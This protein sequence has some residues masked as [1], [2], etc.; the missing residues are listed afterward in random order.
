MTSPDD[1]RPLAGRRVLITR[2]HPGE[3]ATLL[4]G[5][6]AE[7]VHVPLIAVAEPDDDGVALRRELGDLD[8]YDWLV[9]TS[10]AGAERVGRDARR[11]PAVKLA[12]VGATTARLLTGLAGR[13]VDLTPAKQSASA[14]ASLLVDTAGLPPAR[15]LLAQADRAGSTLRD[16]LLNAGHA[17]TVVTA[18]STRLLTPDPQLLHGADALLLASGSAAQSWVEAV[19]ATGPPVIVAIGPTTADVAR[20][21]GLKISGVSSDHSL[22]GLVNELQH[23]LGTFGALDT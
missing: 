1:G 22:R 2:E 21:F 15:I 12:A 3:L 19:G 17:V 23:Q 20:R 8:R 14:L 5:L 4:T 6:G 16:R 9:V 10:T 18:Y 7:A 13:P 11:H